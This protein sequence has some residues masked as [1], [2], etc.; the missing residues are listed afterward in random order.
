M[1]NRWTEQ[2]ELLA[3]LEEVG[4][5]CIAFSPLAQGMLTDRYLDGSRPT[6]APRPAARCARRLDHRG[7]ARQGAGAR[8]PSPRERG[9]T[10][11]PARVGVGPSR[12]ADDVA[13]DRRKQRAATR[14]Q[15]RGAGNM[16][17][18]ESELA[19]ID[20]YAVEADINLWKSSSDA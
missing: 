4:A 13:G 7:A 17:L 15:R 14:R 11:C 8:T 2:D 18:T 9:Q 19:E 16:A 20:Q 3:T 5:G 10:P 12:S 1:F 6:R